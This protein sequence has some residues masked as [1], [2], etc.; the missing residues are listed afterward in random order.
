MQPHLAAAYRTADY[1]VLAA[2]LTR[3]L[4]LP[5]RERVLARPQ[6]KTLTAKHRKT[7]GL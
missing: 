1:P 7:L 4:R 2:E 3:G 6:P 5:Y